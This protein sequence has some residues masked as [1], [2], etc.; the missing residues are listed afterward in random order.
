MLNLNPNNM[1]TII[2]LLLIISMGIFFG[3]CTAQNNGQISEVL[4]AKEYHQQISNAD[5]L[6]LI[7]VRT[8]SEFSQG[9]IPNSKNW[10]FLN[11]DFANNLDQLDKDRPVYIYCA[12][13]NRSGKAA[14]LLKEKGFKEV[15]DLRGGY[16]SW[17]YK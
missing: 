15:Y 10:D 16:S 2:N 14:K 7:D 1:K 5:Q 8:S 4:P 12:S 17:P 11:A 13:G 3:S 6:Q 9:N